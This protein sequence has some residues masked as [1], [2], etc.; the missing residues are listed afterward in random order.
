MQH[1]FSFLFVSEFCVQI[2]SIY[3][4]NL[5]IKL[6]THINCAGI[7]C[8]RE[9]M[10]EREKDIGIENKKKV[11]TSNELHAKLQYNE[12][13]DSSSQNIIMIKAVKKTLRKRRR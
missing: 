11:R 6:V 10:N 13:P 5:F 9:M 1:E 2:S 7:D 3:N 8:E 12:F 4:Y